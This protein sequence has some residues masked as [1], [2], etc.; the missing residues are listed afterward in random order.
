VAALFILFASAP[1]VSWWLGPDHYISGAT[2]FVFALN[3][4][5]TCVAGVLAQFVFASGR[6]PFMVSTLLHG[7]LTVGGMIVLCPRLGTVGVP[8]SALLGVALTNLW[9]NPLEA[10]R[11]WRELRPRSELRQ[12]MK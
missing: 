9:L 12:V 6:N 3:Y 8:L 4:G 2:L 10:W 7:A 1:L 11:T 5:L